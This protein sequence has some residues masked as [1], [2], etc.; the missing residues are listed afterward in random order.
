LR[1]YK[2][3][4]IAKKAGVSK[5]TIDY[6]TN[7]GLLKPVRSENNY[8]YYTDES[9]VRLHIIEGMKANRFTL[10]EIR[11]QLERLDDHSQAETDGNITDNVVNIDV[12]RNQLKQLEKQLLQLQPALAGLDAQKA[13][14]LRNRI[15]VQSMAL[16]QSLLLY[17]NEI[18]CNL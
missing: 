11:E 4:Q 14:A 2:I 10:E 1:K 6:Y 16:V 13:A 12:L 9:L 17:I 18:T 7:L 8:R 5:R 15:M 3:G